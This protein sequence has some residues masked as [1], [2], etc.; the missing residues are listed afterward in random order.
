M[1][2]ALSSGQTVSLNTLRPTPGFGLT[3]PAAAY[4][5]LAAGFALAYLLSTAR[6]SA[7]DF[8]S[9]VGGTMRYPNALDP[10]RYRVLMPALGA[11]ISR[12]PGV[13]PSLAFQILTVLGAWGILLAFRALLTNAMR[14]ERATLLAPLILYPMAWNYCL[15]NR[16]YFPFDLPA[17]FFVVLGCH[18]LWRRSWI[19]FYVVLLLASL[20]RETGGLLVFIYALTVA[21]DL[22]RARRLAHLA[23]MLVLWA[24]VIGGIRWLAGGG[25]DYARNE[26][27]AGNLATLRDMVSLRENALKDWAKFALSFGG[28]AW[29]LP[30]V[31]RS[32]P[33]F[34]R[35]ALWAIVPYLAATK[36]RGIV[37][38]V[39]HYAELVPLI[40]APAA[41]AL[42]A[43][44][45]ARG[46]ARLGP[47]P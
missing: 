19:L 11:A 34:L 28:L 23:A 1:S 42:A 40:A 44:L 20:N 46:F 37:D 38:E 22:P 27:L 13:T 9:Y 32:Q 25:G 24:A 12:L 4:L 2:E 15:L 45:D 26:W 10:F 47:R 36:T 3:K 31:R 21:R 41:L 14:A 8:E 16:L 35:G 7:A 18:A 6:W 29:L 5:A 30:A 43:A 33:D 17:I 39:R